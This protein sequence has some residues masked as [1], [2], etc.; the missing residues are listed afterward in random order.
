MKHYKNYKVSQ[1]ITHPRY[2]SYY[3][4]NVYTI[5]KEFI[6]HG[7]KKIPKIVEGLDE[8]KVAH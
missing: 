2:V 1:C 6:Y 7:F 8:A 4:E 3:L 5:V